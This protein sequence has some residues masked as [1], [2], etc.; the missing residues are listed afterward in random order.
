MDRLTRPPVEQVAARYRNIDSDN[1]NVARYTLELERRAAALCD[2]ITNDVKL[3]GNVG[4]DAFR[5]ATELRALLPE[6]EEE[7]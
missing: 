6:R 4:G 1:G 5:M 2:A 3:D 7:R